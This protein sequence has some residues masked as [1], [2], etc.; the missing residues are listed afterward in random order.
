MKSFAA[1]ERTSSCLL[2]AKVNGRPVQTW[3]DLGRVLAIF[4]VVLIHACGSRIYKFGHIPQGDWLATN[5]LDSLVSCSVPLFVML[6]GA[7]LLQRN[8]PPV[9][10]QAVRRRVTRVL[11]PL[12]VWSVAYLEYVS[13]DTHV[14][15][16]W[17]SVLR[18]PAMYHLWFLYMMLGLYLLLPIFQ[19]VFRI[20][21]D[22][23]DL[24]LYLL[25]LW[26]LVTCVP[27]HTDVPLLALLQQGSLLGYGG[28]FVA[29]AVIADTAGRS[30][31]SK[32]VFAAVYIGAVA[33]TFVMSWRASQQAGQLV[34]TFLGYFSLNVTAASLA[35]FFLLTGVNPVG[36]AAA[37]LRWISDRAFLVF[38]AHVVVLDRVEQ[39][40]QKYTSLP[41]A[42]DIVLSAGVTF[43]VSLVI[44]SFLRALPKSRMV[45]G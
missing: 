21:V 34:D 1:V 40:V 8:Q 22:R 2:D 38:L 25:L 3:A 6:S 27:H 24:Q 42:L 28:Y 18:R 35:A 10:L 30:G 16:D 19:A 44:A 39:L 5:V 9:T 20:V 29:G 43:L 7:L 26:V 14:P 36:R 12:I 11:V 41:A 33:V 13:S 4:G 23:M 37:A 15:I 31:A 32:L 45:L 17:W